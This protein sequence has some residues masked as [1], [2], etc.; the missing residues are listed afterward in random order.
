MINWIKTQLW[1]C[2]KAA[3]KSKTPWE[4]NMMADRHQWGK[5]KKLAWNWHWSL[6][7]LL[8]L[9]NSSKPAILFS[10][11]RAYLKSTY[12]VQNKES[13]LKREL[14]VENKSRNFACVRAFVFVI[15]LS[16]VWRV[17]FNSC[18]IPLL[19]R[20]SNHVFSVRCGLRLSLSFLPLPM[21]FCQLVLLV[22]Y[23]QT[24]L[25]EELRK[26]SVDHDERHD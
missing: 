5:I 16:L 23:P 7:K 15:R 22:L 6:I 19:P 25:R 11:P 12:S 18:G 3:C 14:A 20:N 17:Q 8:P 9:W 2:Q 24:V 26:G 4:Y 10:S 21:G 1:S 13:Y